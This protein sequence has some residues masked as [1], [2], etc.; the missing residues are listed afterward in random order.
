MKQYGMPVFGTVQEAN[1]AA[2]TTHGAVRGE[3]RQGIAIFRGIPYGGACE[4]AGR[5]L[6]PVPAEDWSGVRDCTRN[7]YCA[8]QNG[9][10]ISGSEGLGAYFSGG[11]PE[12]FGVAEE[13]QGENCL[14]LNVRREWTTDAGRLWCIY[15][16]AAL[17]PGRA[18]WSWE[19][20]GGPERKIW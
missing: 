4:G 19:P 2:Q 6:P 16:A 9:G 17:Q 8:V 11:R 13:K 7:G 10:S 15:T 14:V 3:N 20:T 1:P 5:F 12:L 18:P